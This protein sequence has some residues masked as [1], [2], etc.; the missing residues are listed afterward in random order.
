MKKRLENTYLGPSFSFYKITGFTMTFPY[1]HM[2]FFNYHPYYLLL[3]Q[4]S[5]LSIFLTVPL[6]SIFYFN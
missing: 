2:I 4:L 1:M 5:L 6:R 3:N